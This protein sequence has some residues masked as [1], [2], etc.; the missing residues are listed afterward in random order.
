M[1]NSIQT[2]KF[3]IAKRGQWHVR[4]SPIII[5]T[6]LI[7]SSASLPLLLEPIEGH[8]SFVEKSSE[9]PST[10][11]TEIVSNPKMPSGS[12]FVGIPDRR[13]D[14]T[15]RFHLRTD[16]ISIILETGKVS[17]LL[18]D[19]AGIESHLVTV[20]FEGSSDVEP[21]GRDPSGHS[22]NYYIGSERMGWISD[23]KTFRTV[24]YANIYDRI[25][26]RFDS[27]GERVKYEFVIH[28]GAD[29]SVIR[30]RVDGH[31]TL[32]VTKSGAMA[33]ST[34]LGLIL[35]DHLEAMYS[36]G[37]TGKVGCSFNLLDEDTY[38]FTVGPY[39][40]GRTLIIDPLIA[41]TYLGGDSMDTSTDVAVDDDGF[42]YIVGQ[43]SSGDFP[44]TPGVLQP[45]KE[46]GKDVFASKLDPSGTTLL[47]STF[48]GGMGDEE[49]TGV[50][51]DS[52][53]NLLMTG[54]TNSSDFPVTTGVLQGSMNGGY[55]DAFVLRLDG[56]DGSLMHSTFVG[57]NETD[58]SHDIAV[59]D[60]GRVYIVGETTSTDFPTTAS[61]Y[62]MAIGFAQKTAFVSVLT[63]D[64]GVMQYSSVFGKARSTIARAI[65]VDGTGRAYLTGD[66]DNAVLPTR[67]AI[68]EHLIDGWEA[69]YAIFDPWASNDA[70]LVM[71][72]YLGGLGDDRA[73]GIDIDDSGS[74][75]L[76]GKTSS[77]E[78]PATVGVFQKELRGGFDAF[79][80]K[81][82]GGPSRV[83]FS[84]YIGGMGN[85]EGHSVRLDENGNIHLTG[86]TTSN[87]FPTTLV[88]LQRTFGGD[89]DAFY[90]IMNESG[91]DLLYSS[92]LGG[93][94]AD[95]GNGIDVNPG[96][97][98]TIVGSTGSNDLP[99]HKGAYQEDHAGGIIDGFVSSFSMAFQ[100]P[101]VEL[102]PDMTISL[103]QTAELDGTNSSDDVGIVNW[104]WRFEYD[105]RTVVLH[106][107][108]TEFTFD[109]VGIFQVSLTVRDGDEL[110]SADLMN[111]TVVDMTPPTADAGS[112]QTID[113]GEKA[114]LD[115]TLSTDDVRIVDYQW[116][117]EYEGELRT[118]TGALRSFTF[119]IPGVYEVT[120]TVADHVGLKDSDTMLVTVLDIVPPLDPTIP[121]SPIYSNVP[122]SIIAGTA[123]PGSLV[124][125]MTGTIVLASS[126]VD[127]DGNWA[128][129]IT[130]EGSETIVRVRAVDGAG[131][132][133]DPSSEL[134]IILDTTPPTPYAGADV[135]QRVDTEV[136]LD[137]SGS[138]D[139]TAIATYEWAF[140]IGGTPVTMEGKTATYTFGDPAVVI[141]TLSVTDVAGNVATD[142]ME[143]TVI[144]ENQAPVLAQGGIRP[145]E[146][147]TDTKFTFTV[148]FTDANG[149][150][151]VVWV[152]IDGTN[153]Q[154]TPDPDDIETTDGQE[155]TYSTKLTTGV[156][157]F[158]FTGEGPYGLEALGPSAGASNSMAS[159][160]VAE[161][162]GGISSLVWVLVIVI[163]LAAV[164]VGL[165]YAKRRRKDR[166]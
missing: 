18:P 159:P 24:V 166:T 53:G 110:T 85:D 116:T 69:F 93:R 48:I 49:A 148:T 76:T 80:F 43:T 161:E 129:N 149:D 153:H 16:S 107:P 138:S 55:Q 101:T 21:C 144:P 152:N 44:T 111:V 112:D 25:D 145:V 46:D 60:T 134:T 89:Q 72:S 68:Q 63:A 128:V 20:G 136:T 164:V 12:G 13:G 57:G 36:D 113:Q 162:D 109:K 139:D 30:L 45:L 140:T 163:A 75:V 65:A 11:V 70:S 87:D 124:E 5:V 54:T 47:W 135:T 99:T 9:T 133:G 114:N 160:D 126:D 33:I 119:E 90:T 151:G 50:V 42:T 150:D 40:T 58:L 37:D 56:E 132:V 6:I 64:L 92:F 91:A 83:A 122:W 127:G 120:L 82:Q 4:I 141:V 41:T 106:G 165:F 157:N 84:T 115:G 10:D 88:A 17:Y 100:P 26:L 51:L 86:T 79:V 102:G 19:R 131:N 103:G 52:D 15:D 121:S 3:I 8:D 94:N 142:T 34:P 39:D 73:Y 67:N 146:G 155:F 156:H 27:D 32:T 78:F 23:A 38:G 123:E 81:Y 71:S 143:V 158:Y 14:G 62:Q 117:F 137:G 22:L 74:I 95:E 66:T 29:P 147:R 118:L 154:M 108:T 96:M 59:S 1:D 125:V 31:D 77:S 28:P 61:A 7:L 2:H 130:L 35:D 98:V 104:T 97:N 105:G